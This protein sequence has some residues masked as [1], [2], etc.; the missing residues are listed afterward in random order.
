MTEPI[1]R[2][3]QIIYVPTHANGDIRHQ[4]CEP[5]FVTSVRGRNAFCRYWSKYHPQELRTKANSELTP[6]DLL[7]IRD[8]VPK[9]RVS[10]MLEQYCQEPSNA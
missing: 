5:G 10:R 1:Q 6:I 7:V 2:G 9:S 3:T 8:T 4:D